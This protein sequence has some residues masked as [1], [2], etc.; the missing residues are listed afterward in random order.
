MLPLFWKRH[1][2][3][4]PIRVRNKFLLHLSGQRSTHLPRRPRTLIYKL[5]QSLNI[6]IRKTICHWLDGLT[7]PVHQETSNVFLGMLSPFCATHGQSYISQEGLQLQ[8]KSFYLSGFHTPNGYT[9]GL[10]NVKINLT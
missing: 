4:E 7:L 9:K 6:S 1:F 8:P 2:V 5:L 3:D 10:S